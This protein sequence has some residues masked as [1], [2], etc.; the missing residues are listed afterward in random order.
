MTA[1]AHLGLALGVAGWALFCLPLWLD[2]LGRWPR[3]HSH[4]QLDPYLGGLPVADPN[5]DQ[6]NQAQANT[7][8]P[9]QGQPQPQNAPSG[10]ASGADARNPYPAVPSSQQAAQG[11]QDANQQQ[12]A[13]QAQVGDGQGEQAQAQAFLDQNRGE[14]EQ[15]L[16]R[17]QRTLTGGGGAPEGAQAAMPNLGDLFTRFSPLIIDAVALYER[18]RSTVNR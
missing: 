10:D 11:S 1:P 18:F 15:V 9:E 13:Q 4:E 12:Q 8:A 6:A 2:A 3:Y 5:Q 7:P 16:A 17:H 14:I